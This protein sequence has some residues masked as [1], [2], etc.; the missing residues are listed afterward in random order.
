MSATD[1]ESR[2]LEEASRER[3]LT[4]IGVLK[5]SLQQAHSTSR[6]GELESELALTKEQVLSTQHELLAARDF[7]MGAA[8]HAGEQQAQLFAQSA[9]LAA[10]QDRIAFLSKHINRM[11][12]S[13]TWKLGRIIM[14]PARIA[15]RILRRSS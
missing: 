15:K 2:E 6:I 4:E 3:L 12:N 13:T 10:A 7:A 5:D 9:Q 8:A 1:W 11:R 14:L